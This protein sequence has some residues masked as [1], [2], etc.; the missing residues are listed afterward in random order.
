MKN[1]VVTPAINLR[2]DQVELFI[3]SLRKY[4]QD[5]IC[6]ILGPN[7]H[8]LKKKL[9]FYIRTGNATYRFCTV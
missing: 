6:F 3:K 4:Y 9:Q 7:D 5:D 8:D 2:F 1:L